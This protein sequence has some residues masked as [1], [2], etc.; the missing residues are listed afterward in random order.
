MYKAGYLTCYNHPWKKNNDQV[1]ICFSLELLQTDPAIIRMPVFFMK[2]LAC[3][4][5]STTY[6]KAFVWM[7]LL[8]GILVCFPIRF[9]LRKK[10]KDSADE[11]A[12]KRNRNLINRNS[13]SRYPLV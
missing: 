13:Q 4:F 11:V 2:Y 12:L 5:V 7:Y 3:S 8:S 10:R 1:F 6:W 9:T